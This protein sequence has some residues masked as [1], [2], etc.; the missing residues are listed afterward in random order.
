MKNN[1]RLLF[2]IVPIILLALLAVP[3]VGVRQ[4]LAAETLTLNTSDKDG[5][6]SSGGISVTGVTMMVGNTSDQKAFL[7]CHH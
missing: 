7:I 5:G 2:A 1:R 4:V 3:Y 6:G